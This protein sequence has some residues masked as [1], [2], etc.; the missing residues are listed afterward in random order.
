MLQKVSEASQEEVF[1]FRDT[2]LQY[3]LCTKMWC[4]LCPV[5]CEACA[6]AKDVFCIGDIC[7]D[8]RHNFNRSYRDYALQ[9]NE[10]NQSVD[11]DTAI[12]VD[13]QDDWLSGSSS[14]RFVSHDW[15]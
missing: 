1:H 15:W 2:V 14:K 3:L 8:A 6:N 7:Q 5:L 12:D 4:A 13:D 9:L 11:E 10:D